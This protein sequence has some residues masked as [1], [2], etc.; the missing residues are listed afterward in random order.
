MD[1]KC[2]TSMRFDLHS[3]GLVKAE[4]TV[5]PLALAKAIDTQDQQEHFDPGTPQWP[6][7]YTIEIE[8]G[9]PASGYRQN[10]PGIA[11]CYITE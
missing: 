6:L 8:K 4:T 9:C 1:I 5:F 3:H 7:K 2:T 10:A 11:A